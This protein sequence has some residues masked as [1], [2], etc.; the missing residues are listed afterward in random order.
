MVVLQRNIKV[1]IF[2]EKGENKLEKERI[3]KKK[4]EHVTND[5]EKK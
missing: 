3:P 2:H 5:K 1:P 4:F